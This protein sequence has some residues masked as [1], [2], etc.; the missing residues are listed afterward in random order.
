[1]SVI[2]G[3]DPND[4]LPALTPYYVMRIGSLPLVPYFAPGDLRL[5]EAVRGLAGRHHAL[6]LSNHG[7][8][9]AGS[10]LA[11][12]VD[13]VEELE[14]TARLFLMLRHEP[15]RHLTAAQIAALRTQFPQSDADAGP[16]AAEEH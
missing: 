10:S 14:A 8:V 15:C 5:A 9:V 7:P 2:E 12:A 1:V 4:V 6:L 13:A 3:L 11:A 16:K